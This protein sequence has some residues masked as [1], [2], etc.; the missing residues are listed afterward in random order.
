MKNIYLKTIF[1]NIARKVLKYIKM[2]WNVDVTHSWLFTSIDTINYTIEHILQFI[3]SDGACAQR[4]GSPS[5]RE[6]A[7]AGG[8]AGHV[9]NPRSYNV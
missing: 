6:Q 8:P 4:G 2:E 3:N 1:L 5:S 9:R 7:A